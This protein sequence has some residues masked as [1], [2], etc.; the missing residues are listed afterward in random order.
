MGCAPISRQ[1][2]SRALVLKIDFWNIWWFHMLGNESEILDSKFQDDTTLSLWTN[3]KNPLNVVCAHTKGPRP[4]IKIIKV[5]SGFRSPR[6]P[7][8]QISWSYYLKPRRLEQ[9]DRQTNRQTMW[10]IYK[11]KY[12][13]VCAFCFLELL[14]ICLSVCLSVCLAV[15]LSVCLSVCAT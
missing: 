14:S 15:C 11:D 2:W 8:F 9:T 10:F 5:G 6:G 4:K 12:N 1:K 7:T 13:C 3:Q